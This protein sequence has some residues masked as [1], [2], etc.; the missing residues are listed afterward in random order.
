MLKTRIIPTLLFKETGLVKDRQFASMRRIG[1]AL[2]AIKVYGLREV[3]ELVFL[4]VAATHMGQ[5]PDFALIDELADECFMPFT[6]GGG[7]RD[8]SDIRQLLMVGADKVVL[9]S[10]AL[11]SPEL[12][13]ECA[14]QFGS[15]CI[16]VSID[17]RRGGN[18]APEV[19]ARSGT[20]ATGRDAVQWATEV[21]GLGAGEI[22]LTSIDRDGMME[23]YDIPLVKAVTDAISIPVIASGG[24]GRYSDIADLLHQTNTAAAA[25]SSMFHFTEQTPRE[26]KRFLSATGIPVRL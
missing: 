21:E 3:D 17:V 25:A 13:R 20:V 22:L 19:Y 18:S 11:E 24:A 10:A 16:V 12:I 8:A 15:Q 14:R 7:I 23:G 2:Q 6:V 26:A 1:G 4:D 9:N 5:P